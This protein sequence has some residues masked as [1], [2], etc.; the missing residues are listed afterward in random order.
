CSDDIAEGIAA[1]R[2]RCQVMDAVAALAGVPPLRPR[3][4]DFEGLCRIIIGQQVS[5][6]SAKAI[7]ARTKTVVGRLTPAAIGALDD[8]GMRACGLSRPKQRTLRAIVAAV[9]EGALDFA[10]LARMPDDE[11]IER[12]TAIKGIGPWTA[13]IYLMFGLRRA[14]AFAPGDLALQLALRDAMGLTARP[15]P[16]E[17]VAYAEPWRPWRSVAA[18]LLWS[19]Y[20]VR[21]QPS[22]QTPL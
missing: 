22:A 17:M 15:G 20:A 19:Y 12:L 5:V 11:V 21:R 4:A 2:A 1:L 9:D 7:H 6:A 8:E 14:D 3:M 16:Q 10:K 18:R 13:D